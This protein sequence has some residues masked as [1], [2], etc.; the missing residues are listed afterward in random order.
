MALQAT[1]RARTATSILDAAESVFA[2]SGAY[3]RATIEA[4]AE[5]ADVAVATIYD[6]FGGKQDVY[7]A[8]AERLVERNE[9]YLNEALVPSATALDRVVE[10]GRQYA[11]FHLDNP[12]AFR[13]I[14]L[15]DIDDAPVESVRDARRRIDRRLKAMLAQLVAALDAAVAEGCLQP[16]DSRRAATV[17][18]ASINGVLALHA[19]GALP[20]RELEPA[21]TLARQLFLD[22]I[23]AHPS[24]RKLA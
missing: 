15:V 21:L 8:L 2:A 19:R 24:P 17:M 5:E 3:H 6:H 4:I 22:G 16:L 20:R 23:M 10:I 18:W 12:L 7:L 9:D 13:L 14:G 11:R 1:R